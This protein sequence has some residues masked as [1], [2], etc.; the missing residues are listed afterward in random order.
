ML[1]NIRVFSPDGSAQGMHSSKVVPHHCQL[2]GVQQSLNTA[3]KLT[4][5]KSSPHAT[6]CP[7]AGPSEL[8]DCCVRVSSAAVLGCSS[9]NILTA[10]P[11]AAAQT[12]RVGCA[13]DPW[14]CTPCDVGARLEKRVVGG[15]AWRSVRGNRRWLQHG[16]LSSPCRSG[17]RFASFHRQRAPA[18]P[19][20]SGFQA[21]TPR[22]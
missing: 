18:G 4:A 7:G 17:R 10:R 5:L 19:S 8:H 22:R 3:S 16:Q 12:P 9:V 1:L 13:R 14:S 6:A 2:S 15:P 11:G 20:N 21:N